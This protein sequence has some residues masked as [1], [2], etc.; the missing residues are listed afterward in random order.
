[1][2]S[3]LHPVDNVFFSIPYFFLHFVRWLSSQTFMAEGLNPIVNLLLVHTIY[4][5][6]WAVEELNPH[7]FFEGS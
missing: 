5:R 4:D 3:N 1:M 6:S 7:L 2:L